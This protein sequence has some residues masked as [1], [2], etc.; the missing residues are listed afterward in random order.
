MKLKNFDFRIWDEC[1]KECSNE[2]CLCR[3]KYI[4]GEAAK[5][6]LSEVNGDCD[7]ELWTGFV[8]KNNRKIYECDIL[9]KGRKKYLVR[10]V[11]DESGLEIVELNKNGYV[12]FVSEICN[13]L[14]TIGNIH[15]NNDLLPKSFKKKMKI[16]K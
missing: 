1:G 3:A 13:E 2:K 15:E 16:V 7:I 10:Y 9:K 4:Y 14:E 8:D 12:F 6:M 11:E 5:I